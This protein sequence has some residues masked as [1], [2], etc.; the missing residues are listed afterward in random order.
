MEIQESVSN[1]N[2]TPIQLP[3][4]FEL[5]KESLKIVKERFWVYLEI[6]LI[7]IIGTSI[8][9][10][11]LAT[12]ASTLTTFFT[13]LASKWIFFIILLILL[14]I[15][16]IWPNLAIL[17]VTKKRNMNVG[18]LEALRETFPKILSAY[19]ISLLVNL[20]VA[21]GFLLFVIPGYI[22][23]VWFSLAIP[24]FLSENIKGAKALSRSKRLVKEKAWEVFI[25]L[26][27]LMIIAGLISF[28]TKPL[29]KSD[30]IIKNL[31]AF[32]VL[33]LSSLVI[34]VFLFLLYERLRNM[35]KGNHK[36]E[37]IEKE[38]YQGV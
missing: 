8:F 11:L 13:V 20:A 2:Q 36:E 4:F 29:L 9:I 17:Y 1:V 10:V 30:L 12:G 22:F 38:V 27:G 7:P 21:A 14:T 31:I 28:I 23:W 18:F 15:L 3:G 25:R 16:F 32:L 19:W 37:K 5:L 34:N 33:I 24:V 35:E 6:I 26:T